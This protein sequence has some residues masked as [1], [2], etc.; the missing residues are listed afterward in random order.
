[1]GREKKMTYSFY[2][3]IGGGEPINMDEM[4]E[5]E[6]EEIKQKLCRQYI[7]NGLGGKIITA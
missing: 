2:V 1:M 6:R 4:E 3:S 7:E 5:E